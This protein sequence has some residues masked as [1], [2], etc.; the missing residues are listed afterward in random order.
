MTSYPRFH[1]GET[2]INQGDKGSA[3]YI[4]R[5]GRCLVKGTGLKEHFMKAG[6]VRDAGIQKH[7]LKMS[8]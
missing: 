1:L 5:A 4:I 7:E 8:K 3:F 6:E 2:I